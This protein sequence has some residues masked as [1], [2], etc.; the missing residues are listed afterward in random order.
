M[1]EIEQ[2]LWARVYAAEYDRLQARAKAC[3]D[4]EAI[5]PNHPRR[6]KDWQ[7]GCVSDVVRCEGIAS[8][9]ADLAVTNLRQRIKDG[10]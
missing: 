1:N 8:Q 5:D 4:P 2:Q 3:F 7:L 10:L 9:A 6:K